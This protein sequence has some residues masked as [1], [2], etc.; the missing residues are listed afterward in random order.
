MLVIP[1][2]CRRWSERAIDS[3]NERASRL[4]QFASHCVLVT[5]PSVPRQRS[6]LASHLRSRTHARNIGSARFA[7]N[8][9]GNQRRGNPRKPAKPPTRLSSLASL[10]LLAAPSLAATIL[11]HPRR[12]PALVSPTIRL[13]LLSKL[14][15]ARHFYGSCRTF[16]SVCV[17]VSAGFRGVDSLRVLVGGYLALIIWC[18]IIGVLEFYL[19][20]NG[21]I[22]GLFR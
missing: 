3:L 19:L 18:I 8:R 20:G 4:E 9:P 21:I 14:F 2:W 11:S 15:H 7:E 1:S 22:V 17:L 10:S 16:Q 5:H 13:P 12:R 6:V